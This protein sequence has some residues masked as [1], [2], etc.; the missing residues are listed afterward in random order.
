MVASVTRESE[1]VRVLVEMADTLV[2]DYDVVEM[3]TG[4]AVAIPLRL[5][6]VTLGALNLLSESQAP[7]EEADVVVAR[8]FAD[9]AA[10]SIAGRGV[11]ADARLRGEQQPPADGHCP[12]RGGRHTRAAGLGTTPAGQPLTGT[13]PAGTALTWTTLS[14]TAGAGPGR[15]PMAFAPA[16]AGQAQ[17][18]CRQPSGRSACL[19]PGCGRRV[20]TSALA[21]CSAPGRCEVTLWKH[22][23][24]S[25]KA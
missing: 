7:L 15:R 16:L 17:P 9:L 18:A 5:R 12:G 3:L 1:V 13:A 8:A 14:R 11:R 21:R 2:E 25:M 20:V 4:L 6:A 24:C 19:I 22:P 10:L 23:P